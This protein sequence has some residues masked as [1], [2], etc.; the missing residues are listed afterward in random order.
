MINKS[1]APLMTGCLLAALS[2]AVAAQEVK[3]VK[4]G[5]VTFLSGAAAGPF[6]V[7]ARNGAEVLVGGTERG[8]AGTCAVR[9]QRH[10][11][12]SDR[13]RAH[14]RSGRHD[15]AG[16]RVPQ[17]RAAAERGPGRRLHLQRRLSRDRAGGRGAE[18]TD[19][20]L[21]LRHAA[22][23]RGRELQVR[24]S[25]RRDRD[26]GQR[27]R[28]A[29]PGREQAGDQEIRR[30]QPELRLGPGLLERLRGVDESAE[31]GRGGGDLADAQARRRPV[32]RGNLVADW[33][34]EPTSFTRACG[35]AISRHSSCRRV[36][37]GCSRRARWC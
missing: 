21:R 17:P 2:F 31:A 25:Y 29:V 28:R 7:P 35:A 3:P 36:R 33:A 32:R 9:D 13:D 23:L 1:A 5:V 22:H 8:R 19:G 30:H 14:R 12:C 10:R 11:R 24:L 26:D 37:A 18:E 15:Q 16:D 6:G 34:A 4:I 27:R 20:V